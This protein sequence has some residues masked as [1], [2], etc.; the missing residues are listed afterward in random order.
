MKIFAFDGLDEGESTHEIGK[1]AI[2]ED[3]HHCSQRPRK[4]WR[5]RERNHV[6]CLD[7]DPQRA[8]RFDTHEAFN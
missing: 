4:L 5:S 2:A 1:M 3:C 8:R 6:H 7:L